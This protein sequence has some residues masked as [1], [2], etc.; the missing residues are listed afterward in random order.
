MLEP[1][2]GK[3]SRTV[4][5]RESGSNPAD[6]AGKIDSVTKKGIYGVTFLLYDSTNKPIGQYTSDDQGYVY[7][8]D[9]TVAGRYYLKELEN[10]GYLVD[11]QMKTVYV[12]PG[13]T[14]LIEWENTAITGQ[15]Q[16]TKTS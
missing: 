8:E 2:E 10:Q 9:I 7:I 14:T 15:I 6:L 4:L 1:Y 13:E 12:K 16:I 3:P 11:T 5:R